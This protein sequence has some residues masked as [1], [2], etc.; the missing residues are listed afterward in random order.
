MSV[1][2]RREV[3]LVDI[4][5]CVDRPY[6]SFLDRIAI[7]RSQPNSEFRIGDFGS[8]WIKVT[9]DI[10]TEPHSFLLAPYVKHVLAIS[11]L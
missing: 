10:C 1:N 2:N 6:G 7:E 5:M 4:D 11:N 8:R 9:V 3:L